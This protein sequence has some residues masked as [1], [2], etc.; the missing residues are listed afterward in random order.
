MPD[1]VINRY[2]LAYNAIVGLLLFIQNS[3]KKE[4]YDNNY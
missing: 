1:Y 3:L 4:I 2:K